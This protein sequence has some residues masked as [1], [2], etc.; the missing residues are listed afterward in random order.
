MDLSQYIQPRFNTGRDWAIQIII[1]QISNEVDSLRIRVEHGEM[2]THLGIDTYISVDA[3]KLE[4]SPGMV[5]VRM[6][7]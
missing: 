2:K 4:N 1:R 7:F 6:L 3:R 5:P